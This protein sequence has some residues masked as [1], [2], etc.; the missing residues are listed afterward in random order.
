[1]H[2]Y[3][4]ASPHSVDTHSLSHVDNEVDIGVVVVVGAARDLQIKAVREASKNG[5]YCPGP[6]DSAA[7]AVSSIDRIPRHIG[8]PS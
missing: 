7:G 1:M 2:V 5:T 3:L 6:I 8:R 4:P